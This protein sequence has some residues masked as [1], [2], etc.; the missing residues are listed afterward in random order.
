[1]LIRQETLARIARGEITLAFR[2]WQR[3]TV[4][5]GGTLLTGAGQLEVRAVEKVGRRDI[6]DA[7]ARSAGF[8]SRDE[9]LAELDRRDDGEI[10]RITFG[11]LNPDPRIALRQAPLDE[12][13]IAAL[14]AR[15]ARLDAAALD[16]GWTRKT[17]EVIRDHPGVRAG[18]LCKLV[19]QDRATFKPNVRKLK[20]L[21]LTISL[22][23]G[24]RL[25][26]RGESLLRRL[27]GGIRT[28][29]HYR[30]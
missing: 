20:A 21:G 12:E 26:P 5:S 24:Y 15:L 30:K 17:L 22:E 27:S 6:G 3:P 7:D 23:V 25:S 13:Q 10:Y 28:S 8:A 18:D 16:G 4:K 14:R 19:G 2:R 29:G 1:M 11:A 9:L